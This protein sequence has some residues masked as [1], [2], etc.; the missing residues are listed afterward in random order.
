MSH[1]DKIDNKHSIEGLKPLQMTQTIRMAS[2]LSVGVFTPLRNFT[3][4]R[5][6]CV[7]SV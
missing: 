1:R 3:P 2:V 4:R 6:I 5:S 7:T